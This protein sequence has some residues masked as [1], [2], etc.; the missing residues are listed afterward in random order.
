M[1]KY[2][3]MFWHERGS[4]YELSQQSVIHQMTDRDRTR[5]DACAAS[6]GLEC[7]QLYS[8]LKIQLGERMSRS[9]N[10]ADV[11]STASSSIEA[12]DPNDESF[13]QSQTQ[14]RRSQSDK[15]SK[16]KKRKHK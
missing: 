16:K 10:L 2:F 14:S 5:A 12:D 15:G 13:R 11:Q 8:W 9:D 6:L 7:E 3:D 1:I 4:P